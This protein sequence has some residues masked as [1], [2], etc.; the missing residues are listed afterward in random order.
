M[1]NAVIF[2]DH[3]EYFS[4]IWYKFIDVWLSLWSF[5]IFFKFG[6]VWAEKNLAT[7]FND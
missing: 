4:I 7:L 1:E 5:G 6:N 2:Y 3:L